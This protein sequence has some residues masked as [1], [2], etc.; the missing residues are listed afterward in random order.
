MIYVN[1][2]SFHQI[3][4]LPGFETGIDFKE[5]GNLFFVNS[6]FLLESIFEGFQ[7]FQVKVDAPNL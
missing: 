3:Y 4:L 1:T 5:V 6:N 2:Q 7:D